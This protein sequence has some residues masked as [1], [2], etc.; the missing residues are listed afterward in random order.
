MH[1]PRKFESLTKV[2]SVTDSA[3]LICIHF[4][5]FAYYSQLD[6]AFAG[7]V[8][9]ACFCGQKKQINKNKIKLC[10]VLDTTE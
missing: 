2:L 5:R 10:W 7:D 4:V 1:I 9:Q 3:N 6:P 8:G